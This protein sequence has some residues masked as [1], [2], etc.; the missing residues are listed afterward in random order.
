M[1]RVERLSTGYGEMQVLFDISMS[2][3]EDETVAILGV[4]NAG[5]TS[6]LKSIIG[7]LPQWSGRIKF[8]NE[9]VED[10]SGWERARRGMALVPAENDIFP[11]MTVRENLLMGIIHPGGDEK[12]S[13][14]ERKLEEIYD[15]FAIL[16]ERSK[17]TA[18]TLSGGERR[19]LSIARGLCTGAD[20]LLIDEL[21]LGLAPNW[22]ATVFDLME[23]IKESGVTILMT[24]QTL[25]KTLEISD[26]VYFLE[27]G[28]IKKEAETG[29]LTTD[30]VVELE[31]GG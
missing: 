7:T 15:R 14:P 19:M 17:Q 1:L 28:R 8:K 22:V 12:E 5:K 9:G 3:D 23:E 20:L 24:E 29:S 21:S 6:L 10:L 30:E 16:R 11:E 2:V 13:E 31:L 18:N 25:E 4:N 27:S 26:R